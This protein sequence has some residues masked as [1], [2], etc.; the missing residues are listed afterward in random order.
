MG[1]LFHICKQGRYWY[2]YYFINSV[3]MQC[4]SNLFDIYAVVLKLSQA[5]LW[6]LITWKAV[7]FY[8]GLPKGIHLYLQWCIA[9]YDANVCVRGC[10]FK[11]IFF[12]FQ[13]LFHLSEMWIRKYAI[14]FNFI[15]IDS[16]KF[17]YHTHEISD[18]TMIYH[19]RGKKIFTARCQFISLYIL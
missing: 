7:S 9:P 5:F 12:Q 18:Y 1:V 3:K 15:E 2:N 13:Y 10:V 16:W 14:N 4:H 8:G 6:Q 11:L 17:M 19:L